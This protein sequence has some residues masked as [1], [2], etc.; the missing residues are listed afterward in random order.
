MY[1]FHSLRALL[2]QKDVKLIKVLKSLA[3]RLRAL[4]IQKDVKLILGFFVTSVGLRA[5]LIQ[6]DVKLI[7]S[8]TWVGS[9]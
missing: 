4:L 6:K 8:P 5:L 2:I 7:H 1:L 3:I 9:V